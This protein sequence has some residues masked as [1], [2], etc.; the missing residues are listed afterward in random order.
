MYFAVSFAVKFAVKFAAA[1]GATAASILIA[2]LFM[3]GPFMI[4]LFKKSSA[5]Q[6]EQW[7][8]NTPRQIGSRDEEDP[9]R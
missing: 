9:R 4:G 8:E 2:G 6:K 1:G 3:I 7:R 5:P